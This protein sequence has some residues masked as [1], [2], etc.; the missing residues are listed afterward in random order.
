MT[1]LSEA[2]NRWTAHARRRYLVALPVTAL[3]LDLAIMLAIGFVAIVGRRELDI[4]TASAS[5]ES[6][7]TVTGPAIILG[8]VATIALAGG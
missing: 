1:Q 6:T 7:L 5:V 4:F 2:T 8:W 3:A